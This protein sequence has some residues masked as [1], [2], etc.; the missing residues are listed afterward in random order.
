MAKAQTPPGNDPDS[1]K[2]FNMEMG[3]NRSIFR[4]SMDPNR[5]ANGLALTPPMAADTSCLVPFQDPLMPVS[6]VLSW[7]KI[8]R[9]LHFRM[10]GQSG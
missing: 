8:C 5:T 7:H 3:P 10:T 4:P 9:A 2:L 1:Q 6:Y